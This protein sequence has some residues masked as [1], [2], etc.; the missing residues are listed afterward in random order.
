LIFFFFL[1]PPVSFSL[2]GTLFGFLFMTF[3][4]F[5]Q[6][7]FF[8]FQMSLTQKIKKTFQF[9]IFSCLSICF[10]IFL[11]P[12]FKIGLFSHFIFFSQR[13]EKKTSCFSLFHNGLRKSFILKKKKKDEIFFLKEWF[14]SKYVIFL[15]ILRKK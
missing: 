3:F 12:I 9:F 15:F 7:F 1:L 13:G 5:F 6:P 11:F 2:R 14:E 10:S 4:P 8:L